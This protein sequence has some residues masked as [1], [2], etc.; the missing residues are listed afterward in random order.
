LYWPQQTAD[1][2]EASYQP[3]IALNGKP[4]VE[5]NSEVGLECC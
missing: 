5:S 4:P 3:I 2:K 1:G